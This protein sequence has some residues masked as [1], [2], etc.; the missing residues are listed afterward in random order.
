M[1]QRK[2]T[3]MPIQVATAPYNIWTREEFDK[4]ISVSTREHIAENL[5]RFALPEPSEDEVQMI[6]AMVVSEINYNIVPAGNA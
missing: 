2:T 5:E 4:W 3:V 6:M 1:R